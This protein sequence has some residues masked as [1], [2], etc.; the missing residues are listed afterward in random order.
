VL[1]L[2]TSGAPAP[3]RIVKTAGGLLAGMPRRPGLVELVVVLD[4]R[5]GVRRREWDR[6]RAPSRRCGH[7]PVAAPNMRPR[8]RSRGETSLPWIME[9]RIGTHRGLVPS[10]PESMQKEDRC[11]RARV[12]TGDSRQPTNDVFI[13]SKLMQGSCGSSCAKLPN[14]MPVPLFMLASRSRTVKASSLE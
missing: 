4:E 8:A 12:G 14:L 10:A 3:D 11:G 9:G 5:H 6:P 13:R 1:E 7:F 2:A